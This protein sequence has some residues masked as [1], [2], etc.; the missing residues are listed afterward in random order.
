MD[1]VLH[2]FGQSDQKVFVDEIQFGLLQRPLA[3]RRPALGRVAAKERNLQPH[4]ARIAVGLF[5]YD[6]F[7]K[8]LNV[9]G[10]GPLVC[11]FSKNDTNSPFCC[12]LFYALNS[13]G[14]CRRSAEN[15]NTRRADP[16]AFESNWC[17]SAFLACQT[18]G[19]AHNQHRNKPHYVHSAEPTLQNPSTPCVRG[20]KPGEFPSTHWCCGQTWADWPATERACWLSHWCAAHG[21]GSSCTDRRPDW[22]KT[23][24]RFLAHD[25]R[26]LPNYRR[27]L[28]S[29][30]RHGATPIW[31][32]IMWLVNVH[33]CW[34]HAFVRRQERRMLKRSNATVDVH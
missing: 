23:S 7:V 25:C 17:R 33:H 28:C 4:V 26:W 20:T 8:S 21:N 13:A 2:L 10:C 18:C 22:W 5:L 6:A 14:N 9:A 29:G 1:K 31:T 30:F 3:A 19:R 24:I 27:N 12:R 34:P 32:T 15:N 16:A 11:I